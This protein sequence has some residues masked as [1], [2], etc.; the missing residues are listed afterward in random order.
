[1]RHSVSFGVVGASIVLASTVAIPLPARAATV[2]T[3]PGSCSAT[4]QACIDNAAAGDVIDLQAN[5]LSSEF[6]SIPKSLSIFSLPGFSPTLLGIVV[7]DSGSAAPMSVTLDGFA[8]TEYIAATFSG[9]SGHSLTVNDVSVAQSASASSSGPG[10]SLDAE[11]PANFSVTGSHVSFSNEWAGIDAFNNSSGPVS[12]QAIGNF[13]TAHGAMY[14]GSGIELDTQSTGSMQADV[15]NNAI[16]DVADC[17]C[18]GASGIFIYPQSTSLM[19]VNLVGNTFSAVKSVDVGIRNSL[20]AGGLSTLYAFNNIFANSTSAALYLDDSESIPSRSVLHAGF[21]DYYKNALP[22][23]VG[24]RTIGSG[25]LSVKPKFV[26]PGTGNLELASTSGLIN[27]GQVC[28]PGG[29]ANLDAAGHG[30]LFGSSVDMGAYE[31]GAGTPTGLALVGT[32][33]PDTITGTSGADILCGGGGNDVLNGKGGNDY[34]DGG[35]G[36][37]KI[38]GGSGSD[39]LFG[40]AGTDTLCGRDGVKGNDHLDGGAGIDGYRIDRGDVATHVEHVVTC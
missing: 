2:W 19:N 35:A 29:V 30:R 14:A 12:F 23:D 13:I 9:G 34:I 11:A 22:N 24:T 16:W 26:A 6:V 20:A 40:G 18:G 4:L 7:Y 17:N 5:D 38:T 21:N 25:N 39:M 8:V 1:M 15:M 28:S 27:K 31:R 33:G 10:I 37:D 36:N 32:S 3:Y